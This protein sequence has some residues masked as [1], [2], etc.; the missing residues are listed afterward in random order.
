M[1]L[2]IS[3]KCLGL[4]EAVGEFY[5][6]ARWQ[7]C[8]VHWYRNIFSEFRKAKVEGGGGDAQGDPRPGGSRRR[9]RRRRR[10]WWRN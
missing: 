10:L 9:P 5:P 7:R 3:D 4:V 6:E 1:Q 2:I 8:V